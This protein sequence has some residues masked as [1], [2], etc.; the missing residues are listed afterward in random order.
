MKQFADASVA[1]S[2]QVKTAPAMIYSDK[3]IHLFVFSCFFFF[4]YRF[5]DM[6]RFL[7]CIRSS[8]L[9]LA[10]RYRGSYMC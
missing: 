6:Y 1:F 2:F 8:F 7:E 5:L 10:P 3:I 4:I 9:K